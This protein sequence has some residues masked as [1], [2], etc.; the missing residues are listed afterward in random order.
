MSKTIKT[1]L[2]AL[3]GVALTT[4]MAGT[5]MADPA[6]VYD[7]GGKFD[8][9]FNESAYN[10]AQRFMDETGQ[11]YQD[12]E[13]SGDAQREQA[14]RQ[15]AARGNNPIVLPGFS[16]ETALRSVA[17]DF[18]DTSFLII[19]TVVDDIENVRS[20]VFK[21]HEGSF[22]VG[23]LAAMATESGTI[24]F[25]PAFD[26][27]LLQAFG[28]GYKQG[29]AYIDP[30]VEVIETAIGTGFDAFNNP[31]GGT[32]VALSQ[33]D[34]GADVIYHAAGGAGVG[35]LQA[36]ADSGVLG[37]GV[38]SNQNHLHPGQVLTSMIKRVD[39]AVYNAFEDFA[40]D[41]WTNDVQVLGLAEEGVGAAFD[42]NNA[43]LITDEMRTTVDEI[44]A[45]I[46]SG[47]IVVHDY[48][49]DESCPV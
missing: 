33:I 27:S 32:E 48:R 23:A 36:A 15:F 12:L 38:D 49:E 25:I 39:V 17:P 42:D 13:I 2:A 26:F 22:L 6:L 31:G 45:A 43:E 20:V 19:D 30:E 3:A 21:E 4:L 34:R 8:A 18:P 10:G 16:W 5:A 24:G 7:G 35:V 1:G 9:S 29:A 11:A 44:T 41:E 47:E 37:I 40:N 14:I 28:C 46:I